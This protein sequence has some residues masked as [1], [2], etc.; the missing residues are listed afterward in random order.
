MQ[1][2]CGRTFTQT[3]DSAFYRMHKPKWLVV[4]VS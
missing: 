2:L 4:A 3:K 1:T